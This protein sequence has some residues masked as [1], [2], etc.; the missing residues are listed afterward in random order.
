VY[1]RR[2]C[3]IIEQEPVDNVVH[4]IVL[5]PTP[6]VANA[7]EE[8]YPKGGS[9]RANVVPA[10]LEHDSTINVAGMTVLPTTPLTDINFAAVTISYHVIA[11][12]G[13][14]VLPR[15][16]PATRTTNNSALVT[17]SHQV[18]MVVGIAAP[19]ETLSVIDA[20]LTIP[21]CLHLKAYS[22]C[23]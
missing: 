11:D 7:L 3:E 17:T 13:V 20:S 9:S 1:L 4:V 5:S 2:C 23:H 12:V 15:T 8:P 19:L 6:H 16:P 22:A 21:T 10:P 14:A 18:E